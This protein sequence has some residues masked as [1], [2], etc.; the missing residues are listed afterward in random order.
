[1]IVIDICTLCLTKSVRISGLKKTGK[2]KAIANGRNPRRK[3]NDGS[4]RKD[5][6]QAIEAIEVD[7]LRVR[8]RGQDNGGNPVS[9]AVRH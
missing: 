8:W 1:V 7:A 2:S 9:E 6:E 3:V 5:T 4:Q